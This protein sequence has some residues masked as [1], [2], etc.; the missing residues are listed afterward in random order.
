VS[1]PWE[2]GVRVEAAGE[3]LAVADDR[4]D[5]AGVDAAVPVLVWDV[6]SGAQA[7]VTM[8]GL[9]TEERIL[10]CRLLA[11]ALFDLLHSPETST[12]AMLRKQVVRGEI[13]DRMEPCLR[14]GGSWKVGADTGVRY[15]YRQGSG[16]I[17]DRFRRRV[18]CPVCQPAG[19]DDTTAGTGLVAVDS[20]IEE[21]ERR[22]LSSDEAGTKPGLI[23]SWLCN[24]CAGTGLEP[25]RRGPTG[26]RLVCRACST[27]TRPGFRQHSPFTLTLA[28]PS[29]GDP[30]LVLEQAI[31]RRDQAGS[32]HELEQCLAVLRRQDPNRHRVYWQTCVLHERATVDLGER[33]HRWLQEADHDLVA[34]MPALIRVPG[35]LLAQEKT[36]RNV[37]RNV[38]GARAHDQRSLAQRNGEICR[39]HR[40]GERTVAELTREFGLQKSA[41]YEILSRAS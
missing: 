5:R 10:H 38:N 12:G 25:K 30:E 22:A 8:T 21:R 40:T 14:C 28:D 19:A 31:E 26:E 33:E 20:H 17:V 39:L 29:R 37:L 6:A 34:M 1:A 4:R 3:A 32:F 41:L 35:Y 11:G 36:L 16:W 7:G 9:V 2:G 23:E 13:A 27:S 18:P 24:V 15:G